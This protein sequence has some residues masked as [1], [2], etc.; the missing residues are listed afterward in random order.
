MFDNTAT[1]WPVSALPLRKGAVGTHV[2]GVVVV[3][4]IL[5]HR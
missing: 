2:G 5:A 1:L 4:V 3:Q